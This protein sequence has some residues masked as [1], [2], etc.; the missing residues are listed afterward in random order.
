M[1]YIITNYEIFFGAEKLSKSSSYVSKRMRLL[2]LPDDV[3]QLLCDSEISVSTGEELLSIKESD[4]Q[5]KF[6]MMVVNQSMSSKKLRKIIKEEKCQLDNHISFPYSYNGNEKEKFFKAFDK[7]IISLR[8]AMNRLTMIIEKIEDNWILHE[9]LMNHKNTI[10]FQ[11]DLLIMEKKQY[12][13][14]KHFFDRILY[15][16][17]R[18]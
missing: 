16:T 9:I 13:S 18:K 5:S 10:H 4:K 14:R 1:S 7:S 12:L 15:D 17:R 6:G 3:F 11:I 2:D 8:I